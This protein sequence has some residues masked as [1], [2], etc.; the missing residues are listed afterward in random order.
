MQRKLVTG[1]I[2]EPIT[3][4]EVKNYIK[5]EHTTD[6]DLIDSLITTA[7]TTVE[8]YTNRSILSTVWGTY[9][10]GFPNDPFTL[11]PS[12]LQSVSGIYYQDTD[13]AAQT[14]AA[15]DYHVNTAHLPGSIDFDNS[16]FSAPDVYDKPANVKAIYTSGFASSGEVPEPLR[17]AMFMLC[18]HYYENRGDE[19]AYVPRAVFDLCKPYRVHV[20]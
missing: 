8:D 2:S 11:S 14:I 1:P 19:R 20:Y 13:D 7:R 16:N 15:S 9:F 4:A 6:D 12:P 3:S 5:V 10:D 17:Q 18:A